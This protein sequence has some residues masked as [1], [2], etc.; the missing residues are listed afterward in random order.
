ML[1]EVEEGSAWR[2]DKTNSMKIFSYKT[3][4][5]NGSNYVKN[6]LGRSAV[7]NF[8]KDDKFCIL[9][10]ILDTLQP[11]KKSYPDRV[12]KYRQYFDEFNNHGFVFLNGSKCND[13]HDF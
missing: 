10:L 1:D 6:P 11:C 3:T 2:F 8:E 4:E 12:S 5:M 7:L 13:V 9:W